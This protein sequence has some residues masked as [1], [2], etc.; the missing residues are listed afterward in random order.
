MLIHNMKSAPI[1][2][3]SFEEFLNFKFNRIDSEIF[4]DMVNNLSEFLKDII[5]ETTYKTIAE[6]L[7][8]QFRIVAPYPQ[9]PYLFEENIISREGNMP[10]MAIDVE[11][12]QLPE[13]VYSNFADMVLERNI[14][15]IDKFCTA[16]T[17][18]MMPINVVK[19]LIIIKTDT[20]HTA[21]IMWKN[22]TKID[23][24]GSTTPLVKNENNYHADIPLERLCTEAMLKKLSMLQNN[25]LKCIYVNA[26][27]RNLLKAEREILI[28]IIKHT[29][30]QVV[31]FQQDESTHK[32]DEKDYI[33]LDLSKGYPDFCS[34]EYNVDLVWTKIHLSIYGLHCIWKSKGNPDALCLN[35]SQIFKTKTKKQPDIIPGCQLK[36]FTQQFLN[37]YF[38]PVE[39]AEK[40]R[41][42]RA[43]KAKALKRKY[44]HL[45]AD[46]ATAVITKELSDCM[47][48]TTY[49]DDF[50]KYADMYIKN[51]L[52]KEQANNNGITPKA[53]LDYLRYNSEFSYGEITAFYTGRKRGYGFLNLS[54][55]KPW[56]EKIIEKQIE[57]PQTAAVDNSDTE[58]MNRFYQ[59]L[60]DYVDFSNKYFKSYTND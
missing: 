1:S 38:V 13:Q 11:R 21:E 4:D 40:R 7:F 32:F 52:T 28:E 29:D 59:M 26:A 12:A 15:F 19:K 18:C 44:K 30:V 45:S 46:E 36:D 53:M 23:S 60:H 16:M 34:K 6:K 49:R 54:L 3:S 10:I 47:L 56:D 50:L 31:V 20:N 25:G 42:E 5:S 27:S 43:T 24:F 48:G 33:Y 8:I 2:R 41:K 39:E 9:K 37:K 22:L 35:S 14:K 17:M 58:K 57:T 51:N 55:K